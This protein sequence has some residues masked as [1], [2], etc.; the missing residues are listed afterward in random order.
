MDFLI[1]DYTYKKKTYAIKYKPLIFVL[2]VNVLNISI[3]LQ[4]STPLHTPIF[5]VIVLEAFAQKHGMP[6]HPIAIFK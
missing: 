6:K 1:Y 4:N 2:L 3:K 5:Q